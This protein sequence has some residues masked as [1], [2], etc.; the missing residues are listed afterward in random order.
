LADGTRLK[1]LALLS[2]RPCC[3]CELSAVIGYSQP[4]LTRHLQKL[5]EAGFLSVRR[6][7]F[8]QIYSLAPEDPEA[9][10]LLKLVL[11]KIKKS[12]EYK[13]LAEKLKVE[14]RSLDFLKVEDFERGE[15]QA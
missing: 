1:I 12:P 8:F 3:V 9:E 6:Q 14:G 11:S 15:A 10:K 4:T 13:K 7:G 2:I 5:T